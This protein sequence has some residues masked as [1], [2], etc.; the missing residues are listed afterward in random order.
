[1]RTFLFSLTLLSFLLFSSTTYAQLNVGLNFDYANA[2]GQFNENVEHNPF[3][4]GFKVFKNWKE[5]DMQFGVDFNNY[6]YSK[7]QYDI[8]L[9]ERGFTN[10][11]GERT[12]IDFY[13]T[14]HL[15]LRYPLTNNEQ[16]KPYVEGRFG[17]TAFASFNM[18]NEEAIDYRNYSLDFHSVAVSGG[19]GAG[20]VIEPKNFPVAFDLGIVGTTTTKTKY[21][22]EVN[23]ETNPQSGIYNTAA[24]NVVL[25]AGFIFQLNGCSN[26]C[27]CDTIEKIKQS[28]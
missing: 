22:G 20:I 2:L 13:N 27:D 9:T 11:I 26:D 28:K 17:P 4:G 23:N 8:D 5:S 15:F 10:Y 7:N 6:Y 12:Q 14:I 16:F 21:K 24:S 18:I 3:G 1:M 25:R 19:L